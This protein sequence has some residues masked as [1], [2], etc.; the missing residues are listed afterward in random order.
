MVSDA[1]SGQDAAERL[2]ALGVPSVVVTLGAA[3]V[4][5]ADGDG[6][7]S[8]P[9]CPVVARDTTGAGDAFVGALAARLS[10]GESLRDAA[11]EAVRVAAWSVQRPGTQTSYPHSGDPLPGSLQ[12]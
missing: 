6:P 2:R 7:W 11:A 1:N 10:R 12:D 9:A 5:G 3:G 8:I 4:V